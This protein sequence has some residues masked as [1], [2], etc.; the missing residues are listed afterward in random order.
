[1]PGQSERDGPLQPGEGKINVSSYCYFQLSNKKK[2]VQKRWIPLK[3][4]PF[5]VPLGSKADTS[6]FLHQ[7]AS[8]EDDVKVSILK[9]MI[10]IVGISFSFS[11]NSLLPP[12]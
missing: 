3:D 4:H 8:D 9:S 7:N 5:N 6:V 1:M 11:Y 2:R 12:P 10:A